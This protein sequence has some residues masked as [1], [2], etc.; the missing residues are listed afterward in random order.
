MGCCLT[1]LACEATTCLCKGA[2]SLCG[3]VAPMSYVAGRLVY[4]IVFFIFSFVAWV[5]RGWAQKILQWVPVLKI[6]AENEETCFGT[7]AV[8]RISFCLAI[9]HLLLALMTI[10]TKTRGDCRGQLQ[11]GFW[12]IKIILLIGACVGSF[13]IP[14]VFFNYYGWFALGA[15]GLFILI[16]LALLVDFA[17]TWAE[18]WIGKMEEAEEEDTKW[19]WV[20]LSTTGGLFILSLGLT[21]VMYIFFHTCQ[22]DVAAIT[23]NLLLC[24]LIGAMSIHPKIQEASPKSGLLQPALITAYCTYL[25]FSAIQSEDASC[26][27]WKA[28]TAANNTSIVIGAIFTICAVCYSTFR[29]S[30]TVGAVNSEKVSLMKDEESATDG[31]S[32]PAAHEDDKTDPD[33]PVPYSYSKFHVIFALGAMYIAMLFTDWQTVYNPG[34]ENPQVDSGLAAVWVKVISSWICAGLYSW[35][36]LGPIIFP[37]RDWSRTN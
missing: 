2:C 17:H 10:G 19:W 35:T 33:E 23:I 11:D 7:L 25:I 28:A 26:N 27:P 32:A 1:C 36:L 31:E 34:S 22:T 20:L 21:I 5:F 16:Q 14:N 15:S 9:F 37:D 18:N 8:Y 4:T 30:S 3:K 29:A 24:I 13:F 12:S 6:C